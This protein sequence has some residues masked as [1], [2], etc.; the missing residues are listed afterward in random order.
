MTKYLLKMLNILRWQHFSL[1]AG[2]QRC[3][4]KYF[5]PNWA[6]FDEGFVASK[7]DS[8]QQKS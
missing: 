4:G 6:A 5:P 2:L 8:L 7:L 1:G 3:Q